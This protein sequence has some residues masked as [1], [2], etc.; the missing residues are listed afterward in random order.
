MVPDNL[1]WFLMGSYTEQMTPSHLRDSCTHGPKI[2]SIEYC[3]FGFIL[4]LKYEAYRKWTL[5]QFK[6]TMLPQEKSQLHQ[7][8]T[9][10][11]CCD[12]S[13]ITNNTPNCPVPL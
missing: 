12:E 1:C 8:T 3:F 9:F 5:A 6:S 13:S 10:R 2:M 7:P 11:S 4:R